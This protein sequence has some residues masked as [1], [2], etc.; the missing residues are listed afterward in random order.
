LAE[1][2][3]IGLLK[4]S[5]SE[6]APFLTYAGLLQYTENEHRILIIH[7][8][9][10]LLEDTD[11]WELAE[12]ILRAAV[13]YLANRPGV[14]VPKAPRWPGVSLGIIHALDPVDGATVMDT[15]ESLIQA[16]F[17]TE[18]D[19]IRDFIE[20]QKINPATLYEAIGIAAS[21]ILC[22]SQFDAHAVT[23]VHCIMDLLQDPN[24]GLETRNLAWLS[25]LS[26]SR[27]R[28]QKAMRSKWRTPLSVATHRVTLRA[29]AELL[30]SDGDGLLAMQAAA[31]YL[32][33]GG[34][35]TALTRVLMEV[36]LTTAGPFDALHNVKML[37]GQ[38]QETR[39]SRL[40][41]E[42]WRHLAAGARV[43]AQTADEERH[44]AEPILEMWAQ[45]HPTTTQSQ[46]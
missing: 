13:Q 16:P 22:R 1:H 5:K 26:G 19:T 37:W 3:L 15:A 18:P 40:P 43:V 32:V 20:Q 35:P 38:L 17:G 28:R 23:G 14:L 45:I 46:T 11:G 34:D 12:P 4:Q 25:G 42:S 6:L 33:N 8:S 24:T 10:E 29:L 27:I 39:R 2:R 36:A 21:E 9:L 41:E 44:Q 31:T 7:R 30:K